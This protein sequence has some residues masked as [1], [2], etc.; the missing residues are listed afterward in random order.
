ME[1]SGS[2]LFYKPQ[3]VQCERYP[4]LRKEDFVLIIMN[5]GQKEMLL[6]FGNDYICTD[7]I[8]DM[9]A[10]DFECNTLVRLDKMREGFP[11]AFLISNRSDEEVMTIFFSCIKERLGCTLKPSVF[12]SDMAPTIYNGWLRVMEPATFR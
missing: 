6:K 3:D 12:V 11:C 8:H 10:Y 7:G 2:V 5:E 1:D 9:N 4:Q